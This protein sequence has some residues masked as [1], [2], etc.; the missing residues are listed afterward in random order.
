MRVDEADRN[1]P[2]FQETDSL[3]DDVVEV[4]SDHRE[5]GTPVS[6]GES[7]GMGPTTYFDPTRDGL[8]VDG[9]R[10]PLTD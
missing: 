7:D 2:G 8:L 10:E 3:L 6:V 4:A 1:K 9:K 5:P